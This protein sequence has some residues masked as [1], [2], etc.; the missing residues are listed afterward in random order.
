MTGLA[1]ALRATYHVPSANLTG[2]NGAV[3]AELYADGANSNVTGNHAF[4]RMVLDG[5]ATGVGKLD[6]T[7]DLISIGGVTVG[8]GN[9]VAAKSSAAVSHTARIRINGTAYYL[10]LSDAQ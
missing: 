8:A 9:I 6:D 10:M 3:L 4:V 1:S 2:T 7:A 5:N